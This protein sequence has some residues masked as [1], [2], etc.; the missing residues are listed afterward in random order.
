[1]IQGAQATMVAHASEFLSRAPPVS[2]VAQLVSQLRDAGAHVRALT[3]N[4]GKAG[5][6]AEVEVYRG[7]LTDPGYAGTR[8][9]RNRS[10]CF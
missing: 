7:D 3:R 1:M 8:S 9:D 4:A 6:P 2:S 5:L 10:P